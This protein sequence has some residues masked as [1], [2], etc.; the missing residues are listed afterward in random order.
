MI[1]LSNS[2]KDA[3]LRIE[4]RKALLLS[5]PSVRPRNSL[6]APPAL[7][8][9]TRSQ[10]D[11]AYTATSSTRTVILQHHRDYRAYLRVAA[12]AASASRFG[13]YTTTGGVAPLRDGRELGPIAAWPAGE[14]GGEAL[15][16]EPRV[17]FP[18]LSM[19]WACASLR[20]VSPFG[21]SAEP[22]LRRRE[23]LGR[24]IYRD[25]RQRRCGIALQP[26]RVL[27]FRYDMG[28]R[29]EDGS[30]TSRKG[31]S[32]SFFF[33]WTSDEN[34]RDQRPVF[35]SGG[36]PRCC[37]RR[38]RVLGPQDRVP[39]PPDGATGRWGTHPQRTSEA[40]GARAP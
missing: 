14:S 40:G 7:S 21:P 17:R 28:K 12:T 25:P 26:G 2:N 30:R 36:G 39:A 10:P 19:R 13:S 33:G 22:S 32:T 16:H 18:F 6:G 31:S 15:A 11:A 24:R 1:S 27:V 3:D 23:R 34:T 5:T 4:D 8:T 29:I 20:G 37:S 38:G 35:P 9:A